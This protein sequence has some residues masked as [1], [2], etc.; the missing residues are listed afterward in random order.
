M[1]NSASYQPDFATQLAEFANIIEA[2]NLLTAGDVFSYPNWS[3]INKVIQ[4][5]LPKLAQD[6]AYDAVA[7]AWL[8]NLCKELGG[9][10]RINKLERVLLVSNLDEQAMRQTLQFTVRA[11]KAIQELLGPTA[12]REAATYQVIL[13]FDDDDDYYD[14]ISY[15]HREGTHISSGGIFIKC[16]YPH[17]AVPLMT[18]LLPSQTLAHELSHSALASYQLPLWL[19]EG[20]AETCRQQFANSFQSPPLNRELVMRHYEFWTLEN[21]QRFWSGVSFGTP[22]EESELSYSLAPVVFQWLLEK[23]ELVP[24]F[25]EQADPRD[26]GQTAAWDCLGLCLGEVVSRFLG[27]GDWR[28]QRKE[29]MRLWK[30]QSGELDAKPATD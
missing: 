22:G 6:D 3:G 18:C 13:F 11:I 19:D 14:F 30:D 29:I 26:A 4:N 24:G 25:I 27:E 7:F 21:I 17:I 1:S 5:T 16:P 28:P 9:G 23:K 15:Y 10:Y 8:Q 2:P 20:I 12:W